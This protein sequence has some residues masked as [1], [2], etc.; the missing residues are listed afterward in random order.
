MSYTE[1]QRHEYMDE[2]RII[3]RDIEYG[4]RSMDTGELISFCGYLDTL[5]KSWRS[6]DV[7]SKKT[8]D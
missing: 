1:E 5:W 8:Y 4:I 6:N 2:V 7:F 3:L